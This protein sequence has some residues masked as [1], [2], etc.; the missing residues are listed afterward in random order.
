VVPLAVVV[1]YLKD[2]Q[3]AGLVTETRERMGR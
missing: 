2:L 1:T 3:A